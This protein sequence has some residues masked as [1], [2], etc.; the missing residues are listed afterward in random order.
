LLQIPHYLLSLKV[1]KVDSQLLILTLVEGKMTSELISGH[2]IFPVF[3]HT[4]ISAVPS[5]S[6]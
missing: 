1:H 2:W 3:L 6:K 5:I 4:T